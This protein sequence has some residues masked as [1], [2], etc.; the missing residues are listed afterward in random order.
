MPSALNHLQRIMNLALAKY[1]RSISAAVTGCALS[2][3]NHAEG[4]S[5]IRFGNQKDKAGLFGL[6][7]TGHSHTVPSSLLHGDNPSQRCMI[8][9]AIGLGGF[10]QTLLRR[11]QGS[12]SEGTG[13]QRRKMQA[14]LSLECQLGVVGRDQ[15]LESDYLIN[16]LTSLSYSVPMFK[17]EGNYA[18]LSG[19][20]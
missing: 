20:L 13:L 15:A 5:P 14:K 11:I 16:R 17:K 4:N 12:F 19:L 18:C 9:P 6:L 1:S 7:S 10:F 3:L 8:P 2:Q